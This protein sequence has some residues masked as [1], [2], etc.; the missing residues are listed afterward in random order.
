MTVGGS[1]KTAEL[2]VEDIIKDLACRSGSLF[3][4][5]IDDEVAEDIRSTWIVI[6]KKHIKDR[7]S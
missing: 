5:E 2:I 4:N 6:A 7:E 1:M 3:H